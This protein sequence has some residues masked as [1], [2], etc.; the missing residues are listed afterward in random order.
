MYGTDSA[1]IVR[2]QYNLIADAIRF[3]NQGNYRCDANF[4]EVQ[5]DTKIVASCLSGVSCGDLV[6]FSV[7]MDNEPD[8]LI[9]RCQN[10]LSGKRSCYRVI[11]P[12]PPEEPV[13]RESIESVG[14]NSEL[15]MGS[16]LFHDM[17]R[18]L[19]K[20]D[21]NTVRVCCDGNKLILSANGR[22]VK[23]AFEVRLGTDDSHFMYN[24]KPTDRWPVCES[25]SITFL[26]KVAKA[27]GV[28]QNISLYLKP[29]H[30]ISFAYK[31]T[32]GSLNFTISPRDDDEWIENPSTRVMPASSDDIGGIIPRQR[33]NGSKKRHGDSS[34]KNQGRSPKHVRTISS[35]VPHG[36][37]K[38]IME[39]EDD[40][41]EEEDDEEEEEEEERGGKNIKTT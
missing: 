27:K 23:A 7:D 31:T 17:L 41:E 40:E 10:P 14:Y 12:E 35:E 38:T 8:R 22:H 33:S 9:I 13:S 36:H 18:D 30:P 20:S 16:L 21:A 24:P 34:S 15:V 37:S 39:M 2:V 29:N 25:F 4:I 32:I 3:N 28:S 5:I 6:G 11:I 19:T 26:Q 1:N